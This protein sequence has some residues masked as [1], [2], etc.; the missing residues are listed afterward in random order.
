MVMTGPQ[1]DFE[2]SVIV[3]MRDAATTIAA[4]LQALSQQDF[5]GRWEVIVVDNGSKDHSVEIVRS[6]R[7]LLPHLRIVD[8]STIP[9][10]AHAR[11]RGVEHA[12]GDL[13]LFCDADD[14]VTTTWIKAMVARLRVVDIVGSRFDIRALETDLDLAQ[15]PVHQSDTRNLTETPVPAWAGGGG[16]GI[17]RGLL[18]LHGGWDERLHR[19]EDVELC[20]RLVAKGHSLQIVDDAIVLWRS[21]PTLVAA[22][23]RQFLAGS[24]TPA[25]GAA[26]EERG[27]TPSMLRRP[28]SAVARHWGSLA[29][30]IP[31]LMF[32]SSYR[33][34]WLIDVAGQAGRAYG[35]LRHRRLCL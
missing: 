13:L 29:L 21:P 24:C 14:V 23:R 18:L 16:L 3:P 22:M 17:H 2:V 1:N 28:L 26:L 30:R 32:S 34:T 6:L 31:G 9:G 27:I 11:N 4:Q 35:S 10:A 7:T 12:H 15:L 8:A 20:W 5:D 25:I 19:G 33:H